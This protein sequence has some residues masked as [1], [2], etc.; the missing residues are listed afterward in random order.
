MSAALQAAT[1]A[2]WPPCARACPSCTARP[3]RR[4]G[5]ARLAWPCARTDASTE[6]GSGLLVIGS[7]VG[8]MPM[9]APA[10]TGS[11]S[12][13]HAAQQL[14]APL[15]CRDATPARLHWPVHARSAACHARHS[16]S[17][18]SS[19]ICCW[20]GQGCHCASASGASLRCVAGCDPSPCTLSLCTVSVAS[21]SSAL[22]ACCLLI[23]RWAQ[24][25]L[26]WSLCLWACSRLA[27]LPSSPPCQ[28]AS[29]GPSGAW[30]LASSTRSGPSCS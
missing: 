23:A 19:G 18:S 29:A 14:V 30:A 13:A 6:V 21:G 28:R 4:S 3:C 20:S 15:G 26:L 27:A 16:C 2:W 22:S 24:R 11:C 9:Q 12:A 25:T 7:R 8:R 5:T 1:S 10:V 17:C